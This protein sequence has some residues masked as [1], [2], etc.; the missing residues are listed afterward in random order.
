M[1][2]SQ[3]KVRRAFDIEDNKD[4]PK[5]VKVAKSLHSKRGSE[6]LHYLNT[7]GLAFNTKMLSKDQITFANRMFRLLNLNVVTLH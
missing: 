1:L 2:T 6:P 5:W 4:A 7:M 3:P